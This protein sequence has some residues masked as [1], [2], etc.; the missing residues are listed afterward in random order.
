ML[1]SIYI[2]DLPF[3]SHK[4]KFIICA[5]DVFSDLPKESEIN[6]AM[7]KK[8]LV[9]SKS[10]VPKYNQNQNMCGLVRLPVN[11]DFVTLD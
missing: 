2:N 9:Q 4:F 3:I 10:F 6:E 5:D 8:R 7:E 1:T 11:I